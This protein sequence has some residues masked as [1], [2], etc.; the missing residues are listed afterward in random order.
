MLE[1][2]RVEEVVT[3]AGS[4]WQNAYAERLIGSRRRECLD[5]VVVVGEAS[6]PLG[7]GIDAQLDDERGSVPVSERP[8]S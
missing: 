6:T 1:S 3:A 4:P 2:L 7:R 5:H 8:W